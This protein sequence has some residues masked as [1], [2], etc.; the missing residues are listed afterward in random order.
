MSRGAALWWFVAV[1]AIV[2]AALGVRWF[3]F[4]QGA[5]AT[6]DAYVDAEQRVV[7]ARVAGRVSRVTVSLHA[8]VR[9]GEVLVTLDDRDARARV[10]QADDTVAQQRAALVSARADMQYAADQEV[11]GLR[12]A[13][14]DESV[15][16]GH[17][18]TMFEQHAAA[19]ALVTADRAAENQARAA[20]RQAHEEL[21]AALAAE[22]RAASDRNSAHELVDQGYSPRNVVTAADAAYAR[23]HA[24][25]ERARDAILTSDAAL[26]AARAKTAQ[27][28]AGASAADAARREATAAVSAAAGRTA[29]SAS[30]RHTQSQAAHA[31]QAKAAL[32]AA[33][34][35]ARLARDQ[36]ADTRVSAPVDGWVAV[37]SVNAGQSIAPTDSLFVI[38]PERGLYVTANFKETQLRDIRLGERARVHVDASGRTIDGHVEAIGAS[39]MNITSAAPPAPSNTFVK[40]VQRVPVRI[41]IDDASPGILRP[42][43]SVEV[44]VER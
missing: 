12:A 21:P 36:L 5:V 3:V 37:R 16:R 11:H 40:V 1:I 17:V 32:D 4:V 9:A 22:R 43:M 23:A 24:D 41:A 44:Q 29:L 25:V 28:A 7:T 13:A 33:M 31:A 14:G 2:A 34:H 35:D 27:D 10:A 8:H 42:G 19:S 20:V 26:A 30:D 38:V 6:D 39:T 15:A 18:T